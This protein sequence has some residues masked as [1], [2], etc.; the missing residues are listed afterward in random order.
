MPALPPNTVTEAFGS[1]MGCVPAGIAVKVAAA[2]AAPRNSRRD[3]ALGFQGTGQYKPN[4]D[5]NRQGRFILLLPRITWIVRNRWFLALQFCDAISVPRIASAYGIQAQSAGTSG[6]SQL[7]ADGLRPDGDKKQA[8]MSA[9]HRRVIVNAVRR[10]S[11]QPAACQ[12]FAE[13]ARMFRKK[14]AE[15]TLGAKS[16]MLRSFS[17]QKIG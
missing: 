11:C 4:C 1:A 14:G 7:R 3:Q 10:S 2:P 9:S 15:S 6:V 8:R 5:R 16:G 12:P 17:L 13:Q